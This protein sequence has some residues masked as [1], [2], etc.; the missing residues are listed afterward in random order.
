MSSVTVEFDNASIIKLSA[1][2][3]EG[4][5]GRVAATQKMQVNEAFVR[6]GQPGAPWKPLRKIF[7]KPKRKDGDRYKSFRNGAQPLRNTGR[8]KASFSSSFRRVSAREYECIVTSSRPDA[9]WQQNG[10]KS[11]GPNF[12][13]LTKRA[14]RTHVNGNNPKK[15]GL[16]LGVDYIMAWR[17]VTVPARPMID[18]S[19]ATNRDEIVKAALKKEQ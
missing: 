5:A 3:L 1:K 12:I 8:L 14:A 18:Y 2:F 17:G 19:N 6:G 10:F 9:A 11:I 13:P 15:E 4:A 7:G 16:K